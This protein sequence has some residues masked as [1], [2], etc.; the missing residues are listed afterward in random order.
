MQD[1]QKIGCTTITSMDGLLIIEQIQCHY[2]VSFTHQDGRSQTSTSS[3][4]VPTCIYYWPKKHEITFKSTSSIDM[5]I[6]VVCVHGL[7]MMYATPANID[8]NWQ[9]SGT[10]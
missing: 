2:Y 3:S 9:I 6:V 10:C 7:T 8:H 4:A 1:Q 5:Y